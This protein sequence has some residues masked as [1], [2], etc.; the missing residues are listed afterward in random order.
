MRGKLVLTRKTGESIRLSGGIAI[1]V[2]LIGGGRVR[3]GIVAPPS[4]VV[5]RSELPG[6]A[7]LVPFVGP[8]AIANPDPQVA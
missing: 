3:L 1:T 2:E 7:D 8:V 5:L 6:A 4:V